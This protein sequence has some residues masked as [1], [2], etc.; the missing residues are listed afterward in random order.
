MDRT[1]RI[2]LAVLGAVVCLL[3]P[4]AHAQPKGKKSYDF[5]GRVEKVDSAAKRITVANEKIPGWMDAMTMQY[6]VDKP[7]EV[8]KKLKAGDQITAT[9]YDGD[10]TLY[11]VQVAAPP[12]K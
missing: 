11:N 10:D 9:V 5:K 4:L 6:K 2:R 12:R 7:D 1:H 8:I 3:M